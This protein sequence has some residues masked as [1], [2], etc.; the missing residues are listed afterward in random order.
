[1]NRPGPS[2]LLRVEIVARVTTVVRLTLSPRHRMLLALCSVVVSGLLMA[3]L[4]SPGPLFRLVFARLHAL[5]VPASSPLTMMTR[6][7]WRPFAREAEED[8]QAEVAAEMSGGAGEDSVFVAD[9]DDDDDED[10]EEARPPTPPPQPKKK[11]VV[12]RKTKKAAAEE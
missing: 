6:V 8:A 5:P 4:V 1:M 2:L 9:S 10:E 11:R 12:K 3:S 7:R